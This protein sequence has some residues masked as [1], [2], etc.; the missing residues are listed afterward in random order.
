MIKHLKAN[1][2]VITYTKKTVELQKGRSTVKIIID[3]T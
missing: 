1:D 3:Y 2:T